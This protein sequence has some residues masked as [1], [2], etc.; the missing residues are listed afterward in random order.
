MIVQGNIYWADLGEP[1]GSAQGYVR[2]VVVV[3]SDLFNHSRI[4]TVIVCAIT[5]NLA[6]AKSPGNLLLDK[7]ET[8]LPK[9]SVVNVS[10]I[11]TLAKEELTEKVGTLS[12]KRVRQILDGIS[13][14]LEPVE[15]STT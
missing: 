11:F 8:N 7:A 6:R 13:L 10:Q 2:P 14:V 5:S 15:M 3:Q 1:I 12:A 9:D 4:R